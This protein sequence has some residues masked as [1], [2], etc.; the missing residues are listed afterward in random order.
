[1]RSLSKFGTGATGVA[2]ICVARDTVI[3]ATTTP[4][5]F[6]STSGRSGIITAIGAITIGGMGV[7]DN[8]ARR[9]CLVL[10]FRL[11]SRGAQPLVSV[12]W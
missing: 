11:R 5:A 9:H 10:R 4:R 6:A 7:T 3:V 12:Y 2:V 8:Y 1:M